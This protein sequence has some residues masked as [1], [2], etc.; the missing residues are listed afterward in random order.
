MIHLSQSS[1]VDSVVVSLAVE[2][3]FDRV[4]WPYLFS[5]LEILVLGEV[6]ISWVKL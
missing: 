1:K 2:K 3:A 5:T 6:F 4:E